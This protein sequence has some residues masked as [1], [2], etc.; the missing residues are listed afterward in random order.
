MT[1]YAL[2]I[3]RLIEQFAK[4]PG[5]GEKTATR[6]VM[7]VLHAP[8]EYAKHLAESILDIKEKIHLCRICF[9]LSEGEQCDICLDAARDRNTICVV[10][11][12]DALIAI[13]TTGSFRGT[14]HVLHGALSPLD[15]IGPGDLKLQELLSRIKSGGEQEIIIATNPNVQGEATAMLIARLLKERNVRITRIAFGVPMGGDLKYTDRMTLSRA[16]DYRRGV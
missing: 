14:Y 7:H 13:E 4:L 2:P 5:I 6:L 11:E 16:L 8:D 12:P 3:R 9:N 15:G 1:G 10:E